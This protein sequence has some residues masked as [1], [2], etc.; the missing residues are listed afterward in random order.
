MA[1]TS[2]LSGTL[3]G[4]TRQCGRQSGG[5]S[6]FGIIPVS[7]IS[8]ITVTDGVITAITMAAGKYFKRYDSELDQA[9]Y[10]FSGSEVSVVIRFNRNS[11]ASSKAYNELVNAAPCGLLGLPKMNNGE[12]PLVGYTEEFKFE[13]PITSIESDASSGKAITDPNYFDVTLK[14]TQVVAPLYLSPDVDFDALF[15]E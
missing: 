11:A 14:T 10:K 2:T 12:I 13:R 3:S 1:V 7:D 15:G 6:T 5:V 8:N 4:Y 9:E